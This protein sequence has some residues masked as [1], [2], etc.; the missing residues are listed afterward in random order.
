LLFLA[1]LVFGSVHSHEDARNGWI[2]SGQ[3][4][5]STVLSLKFI[6]RPAEP[7][8][9]LDRAF[10][11]V[12]DPLNST[13]RF[14]RYLSHDEI[15]ALVSP[16]P[17]AEKALQEWWAA[18]GAKGHWTRS[19][20]GDVLTMTCTVEHLLRV[21]PEAAMHRFEHPSMS[22]D[23]IF[24]SLTPAA[25]PAALSDHVLSVLGLGDFGAP[26]RAVRARS[27]K[28]GCDFKGAI[29]D[30]PV[31]AHQYG[32]P[33]ASTRPA[34]A[35]QV[36][37]QGVAAFEDAEFKQSD[38]DAFD[39]GYGLPGT[40]IKVVGPNNGGYFG[41]ASLDT[42]YI[43]ASGSG[44]P[45]YFLAQKEFD[46]LGWCEL[47]LKQSDVP[48]VLS[49]SWGGPESQYPK[50]GM[51]AANKCFQK[52]GLLGV[53]IFASSGDDG[54]GKQGS[55][56]FNRC[57]K[58]DPTWPA[59]SPYLTAV[60]A[61]YLEGDTEIGWS[62]SGGGFS[63]IFE[64][65]EYQNSSIKEYVSSGA[66]LPN[67]KLY[68]AGGRVTPDVSALGTC[69]TV[70]S[71]GAATGTLSGTSASTPTFAGMVALINAE[72]EA[73]GKPPVGFVNPSLYQKGAIGFDVTSGNNKVSGCSGGFP[74]VKGFDAITGLGTPNFE[75][76][77]A[78]LL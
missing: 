13:G 9:S 51:A 6:M 72:A 35:A 11:A 28:I 22:G 27:S 66:A 46:L 60:G 65:P 64:A 17:G 2:A 55:G 53:S 25:L 32:I 31:I 69:Y 19:R 3:A 59:S 24:R 71:G 10:H 56:I 74:A 52:L 29:I 61:T 36:S 73:K 38:V 41:E 76:L 37:S 47:V 49:I 16:Q 68:P 26:P 20:H 12:S 1:S 70:W 45:T 58:F 43:T 40:T 18:A 14:R 63:A 42:Q 21:F 23:G 75:Q 62:S 57:A 78:I 48:K 34:N 4:A 33:N 15:A 67:P 39:K 7:S 54:T 8:S 50:E 44:A 77:R 5:A 30:P